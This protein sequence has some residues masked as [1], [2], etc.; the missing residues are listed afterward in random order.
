MEGETAH[1]E[2]GA[3]P[4]HTAPRRKKDYAMMIADTLKQKIKRKHV[5]AGLIYLM[6]GLII[7]LPITANMQSVVPGTGGDVYTNMWGI[8]WASY[9]TFVTHGNLWFTH[10][11][12]WPVGDNVAYFTF[13]PIAAI[14][15]AP[16]QAVSVAFAYDVIFFLGF[17]ISG[18]GMFVLADYITKNSYAAFIA[19]II[20][21]YSA[22]H[23]AAAMGHLD[24]MIIGWVPLA[25]YF[26]IRMVKDERKYL[27]AV[28]LAVSLVFA[29]FMGDVEQGILT[30]VLLFVT[31]VCYLLYSHTR[32][33]V[34][35]RRFWYAIGISVIATL[36]LGSWGL[37]PLAHGYLAPGGAANVNSRNTLSNDAEWSSPILSFFLPSP[38]NG[39]LHNLSVG[40]AG[41][42]SVD[43]NERIAYVGW[44]A[45]ILLAIG[46]WKNFKAA[47]LW[48]I[49]AVFFGWMVLGP[50]IQW[51]PYVSQGIPGIYYAYHFIPGFG[52]L[53]EAD[54]FFVA[55]SVAISMLAAFGMKFI[56]ERFQHADRARMLKV[57]TVAAFGIF[58]VFESA[59]FVTPAFA[60]LVTT[61]ISVP[62]F[63]SDISRYAGN[64]SV[65]QLP[66]LINN[67][68]KYPDLA[69]GQATFYTS[70]SHKPIVGG[71]GGRFNTSQQLTLYAIPLVIATSNL[72][73]TGNFTYSSP[74][75]ENYT[76]ESILS[77]YNYQTAFVVINT[78]VLNTTQ[79]QTLEPY[80]AGAF[81]SPVYQDNQTIAFSTASAINS[82]IFRQYVGYPLATDWAEFSAFINGTTTDLW[83]PINPGLVSVFAPYANATNLQYKIYSSA[84]SYINTTISF[85]AVAVQGSSTLVVETPTS[86]SQY[87]ALATIPLTTSLARYSFNM[88]MVSGP[89]GNPLLF[90]SQGTGTPGIEN[91]TFSERR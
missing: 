85:S 7:F 46:I 79:I 59:G 28:G 17:L 42:Y 66:V 49:L 23:V 5:I 19:G 6:I 88:T 31:F 41:I 58:F 44:A 50:Y 61:H 76:A 73:Q 65:L 53:Q 70:A 56:I 11:I 87:A 47:R 43:P 25:L 69:S 35:A 62:S 63:Y 1:A 32:K 27:Y 51:G 48:I 39:L 40:Y 86:S 45:I 60:P 83:A 74:V 29:I 90:V 36:V 77:L 91:I 9:T 21:S 18:I 22:F 2:H 84:P 13:A 64:F 82:S 52:V 37:I 54:R 20:F 4:S 14:L 67:N 38:Y 34:L 33:L 81:G 68:L 55:F 78:D 3:A 26:F 8:W 75:L 71:Y 30:V 16:F 12:F 89:Y 15:T 10:L 57:G 72:Q 80:V 24:W